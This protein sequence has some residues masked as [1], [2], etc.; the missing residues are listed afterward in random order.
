MTYEEYIDKL[1]DKAGFEGSKWGPKIIGLVIRDIE[2][3]Q[4]LDSMPGTPEELAEKTG[5]SADIVRGKLEW[6]E[7]TGICIARTRDRGNVYYYHDGCVGLKDAMSYSLIYAED[8]RVTKE[9]VDEFM[10]D[11]DVWSNTDHCDGLWEPRDK[12]YRKAVAEKNNKFNHSWNLVIPLPGTV[13]DGT[14]LDPSENFEAIVRNA[15]D[16]ILVNECACNWVRYHI[17]GQGARYPEYKNNEVCFHFSPY[18]ENKFLREKGLA[19]ELTVDEALELGRDIAERGLVMT[20]NGGKPLIGQVCSCDS[21]GCSICRP[22]WKRGLHNIFESRFKPRIDKE[23]CIACGQCVKRCAFGVLSLVKDMDA[24]E[25]GYAKLKVI[26]DEEKCMGCGAC[27][28]KCPKDAIGLHC[29]K[30]E[31]WLVEAPTCAA[32]DDSEL[33]GIV[34]ATTDKKD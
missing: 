12:A 29:V 20:T 18:G 13:K 6:L 19:R 28:A 27:V 22:V 33:T 17:T 8:E 16:G 30:D 26:C 24:W 3:A 34:Y 31:S 25:E 5:M 23:K 14:K 7:L 10:Y 21:R 9:L 15:P 2:D 32:I 4:I 1:C 11:F